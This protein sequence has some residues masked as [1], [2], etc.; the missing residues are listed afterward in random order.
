MQRYEENRNRT[1]GLQPVVLHWTGCGVKTKASKKRELVRLKTDMQSHR[2]GKCVDGF[3]RCDVV[4]HALTGLA[5]GSDGLTGGGG[6][7]ASCGL[8]PFHIHLLTISLSAL[9]PYFIRLPPTHRPVIWH[10]LKPPH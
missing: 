2:V 9:Q 7:S 1:G 10:P 6:C 5:E 8:V 4:M 3:C